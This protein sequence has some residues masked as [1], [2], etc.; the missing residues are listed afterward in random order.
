MFQERIAGIEPLTS[1]INSHGSN[2][3]TNELGFNGD[4]TIF[5]I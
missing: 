3:Y 4:A 2:Q 5:G 1:A